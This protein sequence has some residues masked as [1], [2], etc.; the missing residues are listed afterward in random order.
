[1]SSHETPSEESQLALPGYGPGNVYGATD[2]ARPAVQQSGAKYWGIGLLWFIPIFGALVAAVVLGVFAAQV[3]RHVNPV[4]REN[5]RWAANWVLTVTLA[6]ILGGILIAADRIPHYVIYGTEVTTAL[7]PLIA[8]A[9]LVMWGALLSHLVISIIGL[10][11]A[12]ARVL[13][14]RIAIPFIPSI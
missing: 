11:V 5:S 10:S 1:M 6:W 12:R 13:N 9:N 2:A 8:I 14:P 4:V 7:T 3:R